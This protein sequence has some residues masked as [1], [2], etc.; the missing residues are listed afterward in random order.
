MKH[1]IR[2]SAICLTV[3]LAA[4]S[5]NAAEL[6]VD[7]IAMF[8]GNTQDLIVFGEIV[9]ESTFGVTITLEVAPRDG[10]TGTVRFTPAPPA[11]IT[12]AGDPWPGTGLFT[13]YDTDLSGSDFWN[14][15]VDD[16]GIVLLASVTYSGP[17][18]TFPVVASTDAEGVWDVLLCTNHFYSRWE[19]VNTV[20][21]PGTVTVSAQ[22]VT[23]VDVNATGPAHDGTSWCD[24]YAVLQDALVEARSSGGL[25]TEIRVAD[26]IYRPDE[27]V[28]Q[29]PGDR[30]AAFQ[31]I[32][33]VAL[34]GGYAGCG[35]PDP[36]A[37]DIALYETI[38][39]GDL[40]GDDVSVSDPADLLTEPTRAENSYHVFYHPESLNLDETAVLDGFT[41]TGGNANRGTYSDYTHSYGGGM[42]NGRSSPIVINCTFSRNSAAYDGGGICNASSSPTVTNCTFSRN[43]AS[44]NGGGMRNS[45]S[46][47]TLTKCTF[48]ENSAR[49]SG[50]GM[51][52]YRFSNPIVTNCTFTG[53]AARYVGGG[54]SNEYSSPSVTKCTFSGNTV[55]SYGGGMYNAH[56]SPTV[57]SCTFEGN[58]AP[59]MGGGGLYNF[60]DSP[61]VRN[62]VFTGN[63]AH[64]GGGM[65]NCYSSP[66]V[67]DCVFSGNSADYGGGMSNTSNSP[68]VANCTF[69][70]N[71]A[72]EYGGGMYLWNRFSSSNS[73]VTNCTF[74][75][76]TALSGQALASDSYN[77]QYPSGVLIANCI[78]WD[79][80]HEVWNN[81]GSI[82]IT[83]G[84]VQD[85][86]PNDGIIYP[87]TG[88]IDVDPI[89]VDPLGPDRIPGTEDDDLRLSAGSPCIDAGDNSAVPMDVTTD[90]DGN[91]RFVDDPSTPDTG[92]GPP[93]IVDMGAFEFQPV[94]ELHVGLDIRLGL[95]PNRVNVM[96]RV[97]MRIAVVG[98]DN[99][100]VT[101]IDTDSL[102]LERA[103]G[104]GGNVTPLSR[105]WGSL[106]FVRD[107][108]T[109]FDGD[110][111][112]CHRRRRDGTDDLVMWFST[113]D[114]VEE[115]ELRRVGHKTPVMLTIRGLLSDGT[116][117]D[118]SDCILVIGGRPDGRGRISSTGGKD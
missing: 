24:A 41:I 56:S 95:C 13:A 32:N 65:C 16:N 108:A 47:P 31:L 64:V 20:L 48:S 45:R 80:G 51:F 98:T 21:V 88:N 94:E 12:Q 79:G 49:E 44:K 100:D 83:Y 67:T 72:A 3:L 17:L 39:S 7:S 18:T 101:R 104:V 14:G 38:L 11:D 43:S 59:H 22:P 46:N 99:F 112:D 82:A 75:G 52:N 29:T 37:R 118:A 69:S 19:G 6:S 97:P 35:A 42:Y 4:T 26:G 53:N 78:L 105:W 96:S 40:A 28:D 109:P 63:T 68:T 25:V 54:M 106:V 86:E 9:E 62:S 30:L 77:Q 84:N 85:D 15:S 50:G 34:R 61:E 1:G 81:D 55:Y 2:S 93:P 114:I 57:T 115:L 10:N 90:L 5:A 71:S 74:S 91:P 27:G 8:P 36:D 107:V 58:A 116:P 23:Y 73:I 102:V 92:V 111:C 70:G 60:G 89:F 66:T 113:R 103:D 117:F 33:G 87:G 110:L 76:N